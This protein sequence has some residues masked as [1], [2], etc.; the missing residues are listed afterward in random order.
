MSTSSRLKDA[1]I[2]V[3]KHGWTW[4]NRF[5]DRPILLAPEG[6]ERIHWCAQWDENGIPHYLPHY[7]KTDNK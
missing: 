7:S 5:G 3:E 2:A 1:D 4:V 6:D